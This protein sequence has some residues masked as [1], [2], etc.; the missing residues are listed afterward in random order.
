M[1]K[2]S[3]RE[4]L[5]DAGFRVMYGKGYLGA[6][7]RDIAAEANAPLGSFTNHFRSKEDFAVEVLERFFAETKKVVEQALQ[8]TSLS[9]CARL[10][11]YLDLITNRLESR[12]FTCGCMIGDFSLESAPHSEKLRARLAGIFAEW[13][14]PFAACIAEAQATGEIG[15]A[16]EPEDLAEFLLA[17]WEGAILRMKVERNAAPLERFKAI[18]FATVFQPPATS[19]RP[20][21]NRVQ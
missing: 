7:I 13:R 15:S 10:R 4:K 5:L 8:D 14:A 3:L 20:T 16:F 11:R 17:S 21:R 9:P 2:E 1:P 12:G 6:G 18:A 19:H